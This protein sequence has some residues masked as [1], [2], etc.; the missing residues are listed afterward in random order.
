MKSPTAITPVTIPEVRPP[1]VSAP[2]PDADITHTKGLTPR[3]EAWVQAGTSSRPLY[4][5]E[6]VGAG[7]KLQL[8]YDPQGRRFVTLAGRDSN[9]IVEVYGTVAGGEPGLTSAPFALTL[10]DSKGEQA[11]FAIC[12]DD[13]PS[14]EAVMS[15]V[16]HNPVRMN[17]AA[18]S[19]V[20]VRKD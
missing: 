13:R 2:A 20:V 5:G 12:T 15:A 16:K 19:S 6:T 14:S 9:G 4:L 17:G 11:F 7:T 8:R 1:E 3:L 10:D 18:V